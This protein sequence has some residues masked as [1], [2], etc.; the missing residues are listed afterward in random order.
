[1]E[2]SGEVQLGGKGQELWLLPSV[3]VNRQEKGGA[4]VSPP[5]GAVAV[6]VGKAVVEMGS[7]L[8]GLAAEAAEVVDAD[9]EEEGQHR[10]MTS[11]LTTR[12]WGC[13]I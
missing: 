6:G 12:A 8:E 7:L 11:V 1:M 4:M 13:R 10:M 5:G 9:G 2:V 3:E